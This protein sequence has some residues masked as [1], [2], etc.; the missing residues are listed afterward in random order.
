MDAMSSGNES[1]DEPMSTDML[2]D[3]RDGNHSHLSI[4]RREAYYKIR[5]LIKLGQPE[6]NGVLLSTQNMGKVLHKG[7]KDVVNNILQVLLILG[8]SGSDVSYFIPEPGNFVEVTR[9][10]KTSRNLV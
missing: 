10:Q 3:I 1:D 7:F 5:D 6:C 8:E 4:N 2:E 9:F